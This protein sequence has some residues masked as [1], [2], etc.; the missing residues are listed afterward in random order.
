ME[1][2]EIKEL[3]WSSLSHYRLDNQDW[4]KKLFG[5]VWIYTLVFLNNI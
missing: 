2:K 5:F 3:F 4:A 1:F